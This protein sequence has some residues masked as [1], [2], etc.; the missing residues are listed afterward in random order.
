MAEALGSVCVRVESP[1]EAIGESPVA[2]EDP[3]ILETPVLWDDAEG[4]Q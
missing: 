4:Q 2:P 1:G 3:S